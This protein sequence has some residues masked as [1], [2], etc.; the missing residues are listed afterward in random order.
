VLAGALLLATS[1]HA[2]PS[3]DAAHAVASYTAMERYL[4]DA[5]S[6]RYH[7]LYAWPVSQAVSATIAVSRI[8][9]VR[10]DAAAHAVDGFRQLAP[11]RR[12]ALYE[13]DAGAPV[14]Y[15]DNEWI[16]QDLLDW[17]AFR[18][19]LP[20]VT[21]AEAIFGGVVRAWDGDPTTPC[22]GGVYWT[23]A[24]GDE[25]RN[26]VSTANGALVGLRLYA[27]TH[28]PV[29]LFWSR[30]MLDWVNACMLAP[31][32]LYWDHVRA[33][34][35]IDR[36]E[37]SY[38][39]GSLVGAYLLL[40]ETTRDPTALAHAEQLADTALAAFTGPRL[41]TEPP[42]FAAIFFA[43]LLALAAVDRR[44]TYVAAAEAYA[45]AAW[46]DLRDP[47]TGLFNVPG[48]TSLLS[49]A[50]FVQLY[51]DLALTE[52]GAAARR[53]PQPT[54]GPRPSRSTGSHGDRGQSPQDPRTQQA[55]AGRTG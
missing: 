54:R 37:W 3:T 6:S 15:D 43:R 23:T 9:G 44:M 42:E 12:G 2:D 25:D 7:E 35:T 45:S 21:R 46:N 27:L 14:Y 53:W 39:Q 22:A 18:R 10:T 38:N 30:R 55:Q 48:S 4:F 51:A 47:R 50:A 52:S 11:L 5:G 20:S 1:A 8:P 29:F 40:Y 36:S 26:T 49:Q 34:G 24:S 28:R 31:D 16:A 17:N 32:G 41:S 33:D 13:A 19:D